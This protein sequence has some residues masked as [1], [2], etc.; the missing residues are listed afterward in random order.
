MTI[1]ISM[2][3][4]LFELEGWEVTLHIIERSFFP[5][6]EGRCPNL[7][8]LY[9][10]FKIGGKLVLLRSSIQFVELIWVRS[11]LHRLKSV[12]S[13][14]NWFFLAIG[15][16]NMFSAQKVIQIKLISPTNDAW[17]SGFK[18]FFWY[19]LM[20]VKLGSCVY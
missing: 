18:L 10:R 7:S 15:C 2:K 20:G 6:S 12:L 14:Y 5:L 4:N 13:N 3:N 1:W 8:I 11:M 16:A 17:I 9:K 19:Y